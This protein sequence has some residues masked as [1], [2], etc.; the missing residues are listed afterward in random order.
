MQFYISSIFILFKHFIY[1][2]C[3]SLSTLVLVLR[4]IIHI[5]HQNPTL[6]NILVLMLFKKLIKIY[7][8]FLSIIFLFCHT[9]CFYICCKLHDVLLLFLLQKVSCLLDQ[10]LKKLIIPLPVFFIYL[11]R[12]KFQS[13]SYSFCMKNFL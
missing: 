12:S 7:S 8:K 4:F 11:C 6:N 13:L 2:Q 9:F 1:L 3:L 5:F 10:R